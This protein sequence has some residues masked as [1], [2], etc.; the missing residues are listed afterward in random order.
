[1][2]LAGELGLETVTLL[3]DLEANAYGIA[4][5]EPQDFF[6]LALPADRIRACQ[7]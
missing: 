5:L 3:D 2:F 6:S 7:L 4:G 1:M